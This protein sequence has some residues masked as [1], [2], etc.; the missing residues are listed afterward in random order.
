VLYGPEGV[1]QQT[2][3]RYGAGYVHL[4]LLGSPR[5]LTSS[6]GA[7]VAAA[8]YDDWGQPQPAPGTH[9]IGGPLTGALNLATGLV[10][11]LLGTAP[12][13]PFAGINSATPVGYTA[14]TADP[15]HALL[16]FHARS[17]QPAAASWLQADTFPG[18]LDEPQ[19]QHAYGYLG[20]R[21]TTGV[22]LLGNCWS[23]NLACRAVNT[24]N[25]DV[26]QPINRD[27]I[28]PVAHFA[29]DF[30]RSVW[31]FGSEFAHGVG[32]VFS[33]LIRGIGCIGSFGS[34][35]AGVCSSA[36]NDQVNQGNGQ[37]WRGGGGLCLDLCPVKGG[38]YLTKI[39]VI[40]RAIDRIGNWIKPGETVA[41]RSA[42]YTPETVVP[43]VEDIT[44]LVPKGQHLNSWGE[45]IWGKGTQGAQDLI[46][47]RSAAELQRIPN[48]KI[49]S[50]TILR[51]F[52]QG[53]VAAGKGGTT[54]PVRVQLL[55]QIIKTLDGN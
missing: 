55:N 20:D 36:A 38:Q 12:R 21:P 13:P 42:R 3:T 26:I 8:A 5:A 44:A 6:T 50:A 31:H 39:P 18:T 43:T 45:Q 28:R 29:A 33:G 2:D 16:H 53:A 4:D 34:P 14:Q 48:L 32:D 47:A 25:H 24:V 17:Y 52:Y 22:D 15:A 40:R 27:V 9:Q 51:N 35:A 23:W 10:G 7:T 30:G 54:A 11:S 49:Q 19:T 1:D 37:I 46:G 41:Q